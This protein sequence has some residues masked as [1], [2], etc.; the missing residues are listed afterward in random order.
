[1]SPLRITPEL[2]NEFRKNICKICKIPKALP[3]GKYQATLFCL[4]FLQFRSLFLQ[5]L[6]SS[7][8]ATVQFCNRRCSFEKKPATIFYYLHPS[9]FIKNSNEEEEL[10]KILCCI[11]SSTKKSR[12][13]QTTIRKYRVFKKVF[14]IDWNLKH[15]I[16]VLWVNQAYFHSYFISP[17]NKLNE[18]EPCVINSESYFFQG[19]P[20]ETRMEKSSLGV[21]LVKSKSVT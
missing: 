14:R 19:N 15:S 6:L 1:M 5:K 7:L 8:P 17:G 21:V 3:P 16:V 18:L 20:V 11:L 13:L 2:E 4:S 12:H 10:F 9:T